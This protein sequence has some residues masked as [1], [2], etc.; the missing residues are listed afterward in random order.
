MPDDPMTTAGPDEP[1][2]PAE[3]EAYA[4]SS[5]TPGTPSRCPPTS[6]AASTGSSPASRR[7]RRRRGPPVA[8]VVDAGLAPPAPAGAAARGRRRG[9]GRRRRPRPGP[10]RPGCAATPAR[11]T[12]PTQRPEAAGGGAD[13]A[14]AA[15]GRAPRG[16]V[17]RPQRV[18]ADRPRPT[19]RRACRIRSAH[20]AADVRAGP[21]RRCEAAQRRR[22]RRGRAPADGL[23]C[24]R[25]PGPGTVVAARYDGAAGRAGAA[26]ARGRRPGRR[27]LS[28]A[29]TTEPL[30]SITLTA[31]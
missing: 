12:R 6:S 13:D 4:A 9:R 25:S 17:G 16:P 18:R 26:P 22:H 28:S 7:P 20:F 3:D 24:R 29:A 30:R 21:H 31:P 23:R 15:Q 27:P 5:P 10:P 14:G 1:A 19:P 2:D 8:P 11:P